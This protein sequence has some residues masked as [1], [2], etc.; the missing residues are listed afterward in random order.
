MSNID[1][2]QKVLK[3]NDEELE[4]LNGGEAGQDPAV[5]IMKQMTF[6]GEKITEV[7]RPTTICASNTPDAILPIKQWLIFKI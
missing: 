3:E 5:S 4:P 2:I 6:I 1:V 7:S